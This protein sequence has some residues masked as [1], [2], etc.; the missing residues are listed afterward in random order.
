MTGLGRPGRTQRLVL[1]TTQTNCAPVNVLVEEDAHSPADKQNGRSL[2]QVLWAQE[3]QHSPV[4]PQEEGV[5]PEE[6]APMWEAAQAVA[7]AVH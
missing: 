1:A 2:D 4:V 7:E 3:V 5:P 6:E